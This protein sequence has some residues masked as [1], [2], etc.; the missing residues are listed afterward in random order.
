MSIQITEKS[1]NVQ[2]FKHVFL[3]TLNIRFKFGQKI[4]KCLQLVLA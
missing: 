3:E 2:A 4:Q 1:I